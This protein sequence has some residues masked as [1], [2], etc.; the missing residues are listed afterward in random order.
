MEIKL[1]EPGSITVFSSDLHQFP[2]TDGRGKPSL[3]R[4]V[5]LIRTGSSLAGAGEIQCQ[6]AIA[7]QYALQDVLE[8]KFGHT[9]YHYAEEWGHK[10]PVGE[11]MHVPRPQPI[12]VIN[13]WQI[14]KTHPVCLHQLM[15]MTRACQ[16]HRSN[17]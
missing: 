11:R 8:K 17:L 13:M 2:Y 4:G 5:Q 1:V 7:P 6:D 14:D 15:V 16:S 3:A 12:P 10:N 9:S